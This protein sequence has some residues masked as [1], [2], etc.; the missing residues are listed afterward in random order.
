MGT[1]AIGI[2]DADELAKIAQDVPQPVRSRCCNL[3][4]WAG[5][6]CQGG[7]MYGKDDDGLC[8]AYTYYD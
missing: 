8:R 5:C 3:C 7:S 1:N 4:L 6:E 2:Y